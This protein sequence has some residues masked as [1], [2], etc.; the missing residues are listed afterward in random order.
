MSATFKNAMLQKMLAYFDKVKLNIRPLVYDIDV[1]IASGAVKTYD[2]KSL[3]TDH[4][5]YDLRSARVEV[6]VFSTEAGYPLANTYVNSQAVVSTGITDVGIV[7][8]YNSDISP[9]K[10]I[11]RIDRPAFKK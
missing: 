2:L 6:L 1:T 4:V 10:V 9:V 8:I 5:L 7:S 11:V 3:M